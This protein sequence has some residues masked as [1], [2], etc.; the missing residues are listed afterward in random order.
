MP[1]FFCLSLGTTKEPRTHRSGP[2]LYAAVREIYDFAVFLLARFVILGDQKIKSQATRMRHLLASA[3][4]LGLTFAN[5]QAD[6]LVM[7]GQ[8]TNVPNGVSASSPAPSTDAPAASSG[9][10]SV[11]PV[12]PPESANDLICRSIETAAST[13]DLPLEFLTRL[14]WQ[15][16]R[17]DTHAI[18]R[19]GAQGI[20]QFMPKTAEWVGLSDPFDTADAINKSA[21][22]LQSLRQQFGNLGL[23]AAA[24]NAGPKRVSD[25]LARR[26]GL[27]SE[28]LAY[29]RIVTG[30]QA[31]E[32]STPIINSAATPGSPELPTAIPCTE[33][34]KL[35][36]EHHGTIAIQPRPPATP[37]VASEK[38][39]PWGVQLVGGPSQVVVLASFYQMQKTYRGVLV[40]HTPLIIRSPVGTN[41]SWYR[42]RV[43]AA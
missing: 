34:V 15:E 28:T 22:L 25:W 42:V 30:H 20:A 36:A 14:I 7:P 18:S 9:T 39:P 35:F 24:Y 10:L 11:K 31:S 19:A 1:R 43:G 21:A 29:V 13:N 37:A 40:S 27:P 23:A 3:F 38:Q 33:I 6:A 4:I 2:F 16:S 5:A 32:W 26:R 17:F 12:S 41:S 8:V